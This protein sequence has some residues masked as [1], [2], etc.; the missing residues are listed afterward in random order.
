MSLLRLPSVSPAPSPS[1][2]LRLSFLPPSWLCALRSWACN[3]AEE[4][5]FIEKPCIGTIWRNL[6]FQFFNLDVQES[7]IPSP[8]FQNQFTCAFCH[9]SELLP[10]DT[11]KYFSASAGLIAPSTIKA[12]RICLHPGTCPSTFTVFVCPNPSGS[13]ITSSITRGR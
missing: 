10:C 1:F 8:I 2:R 3:C 13:G 7:E 12:R 4:S 6:G 9:R 11:L 5:P